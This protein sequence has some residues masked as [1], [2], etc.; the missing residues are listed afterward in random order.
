MQVLGCGTRHWNDP[1]IIRKWLEQLRAAQEPITILV[2]SDPLNVPKGLIGA[3][4]FI[5]EIGFE[6]DYNV[7]TFP[8]LWQT[9]GRAA[10]PIRNKQM[11]D[12]RPDLVLAFRLDGESFGTDGVVDL[13]LKQNIRVL[14]I[15]PDGTH[16]RVRKSEPIAEQLGMFQDDQAPA[17]IVPNW[18]ENLN[19]KV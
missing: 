8:A 1:V 4:F 3:D 14:M 7:L 10:G 16:E 18:L 15:H 6:L 5:T 2:G 9:Y 19:G 11:I 13:A 12:C 17:E